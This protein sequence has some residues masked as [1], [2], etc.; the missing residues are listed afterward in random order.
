M[1][2]KT[3]TLDVTVLSKKTVNE[4]T[5]MARELKIEPISGLRKQELI[6]KILEAHLLVLEDRVLIDAIDLIVISAA[7]LVVA[8]LIEVYVTPVLF[9]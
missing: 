7:L 6:A 5:K 9:A 1:E 8:G 2:R 3:A 4:L